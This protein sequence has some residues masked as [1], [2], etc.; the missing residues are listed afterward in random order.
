MALVYIGLG[1][2]LGDKKHHLQQAIELIAEKAGKIISCSSFY[3]SKPWGFSSPNDF[4]NAV[5]LTETTLS[6]TELLYKTQQI[7]R[8]MGRTEK[9]GNSYADRMIDIDILFYDNQLINTPELKI[10]HPL[11]QERDFVLIPLAEIAPD[12]IHPVL[13]KSIQEL[14][15]N[16]LS[17]G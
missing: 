6:P 9:T 3:E 11:I 16:L 8:E 5:I 1:S 7:E 15:D 17:N 14:K 13:R 10:P 12:F 2:N 4:L